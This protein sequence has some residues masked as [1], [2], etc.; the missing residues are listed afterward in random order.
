MGDEEGLMV[1]ARML[2]NEAIESL[3][4]GDN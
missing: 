3:K 2:D 4:E 1:K